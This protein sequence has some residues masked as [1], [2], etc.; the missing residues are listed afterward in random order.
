MQVRT[1]PGPDGN[2]CHQVLA[3]H[4]THVV[5]KD[6]EGIIG[7]VRND[8]HVQGATLPPGRSKASAPDKGTKFTPPTAEMMIKE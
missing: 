1:P 5:E 3:T 2:I 6:S 8:D 7:R 4:H